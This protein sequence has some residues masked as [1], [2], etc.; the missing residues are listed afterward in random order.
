MDSLKAKLLVATPMLEDPNFDR[1][2]VWLLEHGPDGAI[3]LVLNRPS[4][5]PVGEPLPSWVDH[6]GPL[7]VVFLGGPVSTSSVIALAQVSGPDEVPAGSW[8]SVQGSIGVLDLT[9]D[10]MLVAPSITGLRCFAGYAGWGA[11]QLEV[12]IE[13]GAWFVLDAEPA[14]PFTAAPDGLWR[15]VL[16]RQPNELARLA[17][18]PDDPT[19]N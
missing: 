8:E 15:R 18:V 3:G 10:P 19:L 14:D 17:L 16:A 11:E 7:S 13:E 4:E 9:S 5:L 2:V 1:T 12:E 6:T